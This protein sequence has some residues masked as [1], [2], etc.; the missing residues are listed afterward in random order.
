MKYRHTTTGVV[1]DV[2]SKMSGAW[3]PL[4]VPKK[5]DVVVESNDTPAQKKKGFKK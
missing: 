5:P 4:E 2:Q 3:E 1:I